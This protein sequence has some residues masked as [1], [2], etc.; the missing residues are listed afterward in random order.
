MTI[1]EIRSIKV[2][3]IDQGKKL[4]ADILEEQLALHQQMQQTTN[5]DEWQALSDRHFY[6]RKQRHRILHETGLL[7]IRIKRSSSK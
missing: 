3:G 6:L 1:E 5:N 4:A 2:T 7:A